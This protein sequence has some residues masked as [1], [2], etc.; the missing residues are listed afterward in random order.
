MTKY[1]FDVDEVLRTP[2]RQVIEPDFL[3]YL[4]GFDDNCNMYIEGY[5]EKEYDNR[6]T[7]RRTL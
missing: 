4:L 2:S 6:T 1:I 7:W 5:C 3:S